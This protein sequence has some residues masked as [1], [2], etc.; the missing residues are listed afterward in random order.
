M[1]NNSLLFIWNS[2]LT[3][4]PVFFFLNLAIPPAGSLT[5]TL[6]HPSG[7]GHF[8]P[9]L[10]RGIGGFEPLTLCPAETELHTGCFFLLL[11]QWEAFL[12]TGT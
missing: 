4:C 6:T 5:D 7:H 8:H 11:G 1:L 12:G 2:N 3:G 9:P 10:T